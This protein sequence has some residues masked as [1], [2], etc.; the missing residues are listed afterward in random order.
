M[1]YL[2]DILPAL[3]FAQQNNFLPAEEEATLNTLQLWFI[4]GAS[5]MLVFL[6]LW[7]IFQNNARNRRGSVIKNAEEEAERILAAAR[8]QGAAEAEAIRKDAE[9]KAKEAVIAA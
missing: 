4:T 5:I 9:L 2:S 7:Q 8:E 1:T 6:V 3:A